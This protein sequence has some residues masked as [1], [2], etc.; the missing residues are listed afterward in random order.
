MTHIKDREFITE[1]DLQEPDYSFDLLGLW[2]DAEGFYLGTDS[3]CSCP[4]P[5]ES[6]TAEDLTG[7]LT[8]DQV[9]EE[10]TSLWSNAGRHTDLM[11]FL[12]EA[13]KS[14][15]TTIDM[16]WTIE[17]PYELSKIAGVVKIKDANGVEW[18]NRETES[19]SDD[20]A[21]I[22]GVTENAWA[23]AYPVEILAQEN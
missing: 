14:F 17:E 16:T 6:H 19:W 22:D 1:M 21:T 15:Q 5:W 11:P 12:V 9:V 13:I 7:P 20:F 4:T 10:A 23:L 18:S 8:L 2:R 3:G